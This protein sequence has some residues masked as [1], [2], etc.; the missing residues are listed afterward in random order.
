[1]YLN[2]KSVGTGSCCGTSHR[3]HK[4]RNACCVARV[5]YYG[6]MGK[7]LQ[8]GHRREIEHV[9]GIVVVATDTT[10]AQ[11]DLF[12][13]LGHNIFGTHQKL[14]KRCRKT[15]FK[16]YWLVATTKFFQQFEVLHITRTHLNDIDI[17][18]KVEVRCTHNLGNYGQARNS[19]CF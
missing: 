8:H 2:N 13:T 12:V 7:P 3:T 15:T 6:K 18:K 10:L 14:F 19:A 9:A 11:D 4:A 17:G 1:M 5:N 16:Q